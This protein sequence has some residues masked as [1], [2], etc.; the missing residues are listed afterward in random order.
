MKKIIKLL[1][2]VFSLFLF[3]CTEQPQMSLSV[4]ENIDNI[5]TTDNSTTEFNTD[6][7]SYGKTTDDIEKI[8]EIHYLS[9]EVEGVEIAKI[10]VMPTDT[11]ESLFP[12]FPT[13]PEKKGYTGEWEKLDYVYSEDEIVITIL[14]YY[15]KL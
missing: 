10:I 5:S 11:Y 9:F 1:F 4:P 8:D 6:T 3:G 13:V 7:G 12:Y 14:V 15:T 2:A